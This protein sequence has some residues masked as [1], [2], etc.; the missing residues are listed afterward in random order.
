MKTCCQCG[1][2]LQ[3][4]SPLCN[5][6]LATDPLP[7]VAEP[8]TLFQC[9]SMIDGCLSWLRSLDE[10]SHDFL[11]CNCDRC[12]ALRLLVPARMRVGM[13][14]DSVLGVSKS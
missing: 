2:V 1:S 8:K 4:S 10:G 12:K 7:Q 13:L 6:C 9:Y 3:D 5:L 11:V 14:I